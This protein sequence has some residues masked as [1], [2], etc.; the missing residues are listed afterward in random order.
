MNGQHHQ[1]TKNAKEMGRKWEMGK[2][3]GMRGSEKIFHVESLGS[4]GVLGT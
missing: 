3:M 2:K 4:I 1:G